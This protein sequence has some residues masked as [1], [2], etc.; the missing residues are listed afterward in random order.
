MSKSTNVLQYLLR[1]DSALYK[2]D[3]Q[4]NRLTISIMYAPT[5]NKSENNSGQANQFCN[6]I[7]TAIKKFRSEDNLIIA[8]DFKTEFAALSINL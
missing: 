6:K 5:L 1:V 7:K 2:W 4:N 8:G 3:N